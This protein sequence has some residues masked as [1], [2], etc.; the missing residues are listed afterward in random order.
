MDVKAVKEATA[1]LLGPGTDVAYITEDLL[2]EYQQTSKEA[3]VSSGAA[4]GV[5]TEGN[6]G[7]YGNTITFDPGPNGLV[8]WKQGPKGT[9]NYGCGT[10][11]KWH[12]GKK[13]W[14]SHINPKGTCSDGKQW[15]FIGNYNG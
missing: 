4:D 15:Y 3:D 9:A 5:T 8:H 12:A 1:A 13:D 6:W 2:K 10:S 11:E 14:A 7:V